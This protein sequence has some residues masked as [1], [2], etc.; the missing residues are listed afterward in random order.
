MY[1]QF[2][3]PSTPKPNPDPP[4]TRP[5]RTHQPAAARPAG[6][7]EGHVRAYGYGGGVGGG[8]SPLSRAGPAAQAASFSIIAALSVAIAALYQRHGDTS[9]HG[10]PCR[11]SRK[12]GQARWSGRASRAGLGRDGSGAG[13]FED[14]PGGMLDR[15]GPGQADRREVM[16]ERA[17]P[18][19]G[20]MLGRAR[21]SA[22][23]AAA[24]PARF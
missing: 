9:P 22:I 4:T 23:G 17:G 5:G 10:T 15:A 14:G 21:S 12:T 3:T 2:A 11:Q 24:G 8:A 6:R 19:R 1:W 18:G 13:R 16:W 20:Q 7:D